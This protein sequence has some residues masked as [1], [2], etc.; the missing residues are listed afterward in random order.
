MPFL[1]EPSSLG[2]ENKGLG[3]DERLAQGRAASQG[4]MSGFLPLHPC[5]F[6]PGVLCVALLLEGP[7]LAAQFPTRGR[8]EPAQGCQNS[9]A[10]WV[11]LTHPLAPR[12]AWALPS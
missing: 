1:W 10:V 9:G 12:Q 5:F 11:E 7:V 4:E 3:E 2:E 8:C 6:P